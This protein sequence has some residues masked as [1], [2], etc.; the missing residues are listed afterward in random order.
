MKELPCTEENEVRTRHFRSALDYEC[1]DCGA[2]WSSNS[3]L[4]VFSYRPHKGR[5]NKANRLDQFSLELRVATH[6]EQCQECAAQATGFYQP[7]ERV[8]L[9]I[10]FVNRL[11]EKERYA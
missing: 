11:L 9:I 4:T 10:Q 5:H 8:R 3:G 2:A 7:Y 1:E 6:K